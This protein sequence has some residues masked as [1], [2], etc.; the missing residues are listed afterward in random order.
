MF[1]Q[2]IT[3]LTSEYVS[4]S[5]ATINKFVIDGNKF[6][7]S[8]Y[9][10]IDDIRYIGDIFN[11]TT[12]D[13]LRLSSPPT[14]ETLGTTKLDTSLHLVESDGYRVTLSYLQ[15]LPVLNGPALSLSNI[16][17]GPSTVPIHDNIVFTIDS[18][19][20]SDNNGS[21]Y[22]RLPVLNGVNVN[23]YTTNTSVDAQG[24][25][26]LNAYKYLPLSKIT[27]S[28]SSVNSIIFNKKQYKRIPLNYMQGNNIIN[29]K[30]SLNN[31]DIN[32]VINTEWSSDTAF[33]ESNPM[34]FVSISSISSINNPSLNAE[35]EALFLACESNGL[36]KVN[37]VNNQPLMELLNKFGMPHFTLYANGNVYGNA[38]STNM[39]NT[40]SDNSNQTVKGNL[41]NMALHAAL[42][43]S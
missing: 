26:T 6:K 27:S 14:N 28:N 31:V 2:K 41:T 1:E 11:G 39:L 4:K 3:K 13:L 18:A 5:D 34:V 19:F 25:I 37:L 8:L 30:E 40:Y 42:H 15:A 21:W 9:Y 35:R 29:F 10:G 36:T 22:F 23:Y 33:D 38:L 7:I 43:N 12:N 32:S 20:A 17:A 16:F 24:N